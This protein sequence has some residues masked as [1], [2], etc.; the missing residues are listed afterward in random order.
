MK[1]NK[2]M[3]SNFDD[4]LKEGNLLIEAEDKAVK[5]V[6]SYFIKKEM[7]DKK[8]SKSEIARKMKTS[9]SSLDRLLDPENVSVTLLTLE[10][11][12]ISLGKK[13]KIK[14]A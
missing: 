11:L 14:I 3:G 7:E 12:A 5:R 9:R 8:M 6:I 2:Y 4:F 10:N 1:K 13:L